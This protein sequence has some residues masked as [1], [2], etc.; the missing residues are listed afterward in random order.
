MENI[1]YLSAKA[2]YDYNL[3]QRAGAGDQT[4]Y[5]ELLKRYYDAIYFMMFKMVRNQDDA[6]DLTMEAFGKAFKSL[7][8]YTPDYAFSTWLFR[9]ATNNCIDHIRR[10]KVKP[11]SIDNVYEN[12]EGGEMSMDLKSPIPGPTEEK[13]IKKQKIKLMHDVVDKLKPRFPQKAY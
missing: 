4:A 12:S 13:I 3:V 9:I 10:Q 11:L 6:D 2:L 7:H 1:D 8:H 5:S